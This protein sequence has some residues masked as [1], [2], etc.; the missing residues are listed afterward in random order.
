VN[1]HLTRARLR[2]SGPAG[3]V[4]PW[5]VPRVVGLGLP[6]ALA[7]VAAAVGLV[8]A[9]AVSFP[10]N[11]GSAYYVAVARNL[12]N[13]EGLVIDA[14]W[15]Y[16]TPP[17]ALPRPAF[18]LWQPLATL[19]SGVT[20]ALAGSSFLA[21]QLGGVLLGAALAPLAWAITLDAGRAA[22]LSGPR[23]T[24]LAAGSGVLAAVSGPLLLARAVP[25]ST[26]PFAVLGTLACWMMPR[27]LGSGR[28]APLV[29]GIA[30]GLAYLSRH[31]AIWFGLV[32]VGLCAAAGRLE[33][34]RLASVAVG[35]LLV[36][37][38]WLLRN[39]V[40]FG[41]PLPGQ[42]L[43]NILLTYNEQ[44][45]A[46]ADQPT[47]DAFLARGVPAILANIVAGAAHNL[48]EV[49]LLSGLPVGA[50]GLL[51]TAYL[52]VRQGALLKSSLGALLLCGAAVFAVTSLLFPVATLWGT[53]QHAAGPLLVGL[54][55]AAVLAGDRLV[56]WIGRRRGWRNGNAW[57]APLGLVVV[58]AVL[59]GHQVLVVAGQALASRQQI[60]ALA[61]AVMAQPEARSGAM[62]LLITDRPIWLS[63]ATG[64]PA[65]ALPRE[66]AQSVLALAEQV[67]EGPALVVLSDGRLDPRLRGGGHAACLVER[68]LPAGTPAGMAV[69][70]VA[71]ECAR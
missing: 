34:R 1:A 29:L 13:G 20:L 44:I 46:F 9:L 3:A 42:A 30:L 53:F 15:S 37:G 16:G 25:D 10:H 6:V 22:G 66:P 48:V 47:I 52:A 63:E 28:G 12:A 14:L 8:A 70:A 24:T 61:G 40:A 33:P 57:L 4:A 58:A 51:A 18:E 26:L 56:E 2:P 54:A 7:V 19:L 49:L 41:T 45:F 62:P 43:D 65:A 67:H 60:A 71:A 59:A 50:A 5:A 17:L 36:V 38:P 69:L 11:E 32:F 35:G 31:E 21:A 27:A 64:L 55:V 23:L 39:A 68:S